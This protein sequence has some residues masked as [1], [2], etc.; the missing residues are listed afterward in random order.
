MSAPNERW[1]RWIHSSIAK[2]LNTNVITPNPSVKFL[3]EGLDDRTEAF[4]TAP[5][6]AECRV[7]GPW[8]QE[9]SKGYWR[10]WVDINVA[11]IFQMGGSPTDAYWL[12]KIAGKFLSAMDT[13]ISIFKTGDI[14]EDTQN[15]GLLLGCLSPRDGRNDSIRIIHFGQ[16]HKTDRLRQAQVD[17]RYEMYLCE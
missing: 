12:D 13:T 5:Y 4:M 14:V 15:T 9:L 8:T 17:G 11:L 1:A 3:V 16:P 7:N 6:R 2:Y 10:I